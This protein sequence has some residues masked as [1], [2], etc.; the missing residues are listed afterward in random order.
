MPKG[1]AACFAALCYAELAS[2]LPVAGS[3]YT[4]SYATMGE[5]L[6]WTIGWDLILEYLVGA[7]TVCVGWS[8]YL[9][10]FFRACGAEL[11]QKWCRAPVDWDKTTES[12]IITGDYV[13]LPAMLIAVLMTMILVVGIKESAAFNNVVVVIKVFVIILFVCV[14]A[15]KVDTDNWVPFIPENTGKFGEFGISGVFQ[16]ASLVFFS[17]IG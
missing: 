6:A 16:G 4:Y 2:I 3:A 14:M 13:N 10:S 1:T 5:F 12:F 11:P 8:G 15:P 9:Q 17:Y 7:A